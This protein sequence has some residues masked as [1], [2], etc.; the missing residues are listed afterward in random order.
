MRGSS[1]HMI[2][3]YFQSWK[4]INARGSGKLLSGKHF[5]LR[6][7]NQRL[8]TEN[9]SRSPD[10]RGRHRSSGARLA[11]ALTK[12]ARCRASVNLKVGGLDRLNRIQDEM[13]EATCLKP[14]LGADL[15]TVRRESRKAGNPNLGGQNQIGVTAENAKNTKISNREICKIRES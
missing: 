7:A 4:K 6:N 8:A 5:V 15:R 13:N 11:G 2:E 3:I 14:V 10:G 12:I 9:P 1:L